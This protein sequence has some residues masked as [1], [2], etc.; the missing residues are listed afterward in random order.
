MI[1]W[2]LNRILDL[3]DMSFLDSVDWSSMED[4]G[5]L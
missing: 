3:L 4:E 2:I 5:T 1:D